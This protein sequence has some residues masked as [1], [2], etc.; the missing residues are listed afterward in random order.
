MF[1]GA[2]SR[3]G[4]AVR[5]GRKRQYAARCGKY[6]AKS[7]GVVCACCNAVCLGV[8]LR[9]APPTLDLGRRDITGTGDLDEP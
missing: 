6:A 8:R 1:K 3:F 9:N 2:S 7:A 4:Y 5:C